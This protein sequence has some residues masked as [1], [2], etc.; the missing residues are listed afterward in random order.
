MNETWESNWL[1]FVDEL[2]RH[3][4]SGSTTRQLAKHF[5]GR[6]VCWEGT[7]EK[8]KFDEFSTTVNVALPERVVNLANGGSVQL[9]G[10]TLEVAKW[11]T[12]QWQG[13][14]TGDKVKFSTILGE[15]TSPFPPIELTTFESGNSM[16]IIQAIDA[17]PVA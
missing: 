1:L 15:A 4:Q 2:E 16:L 3:L 14:S 8:L 6:R 13:I 5:G 10:L 9:D 11:A 17:V 7:I 12:E